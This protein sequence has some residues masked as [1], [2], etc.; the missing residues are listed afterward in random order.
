MDRYTK[1]V[2]TVIALALVGIALKPIA[3]PAYADAPATVECILPE[4]VDV[5]IAEVYGLGHGTLN[6]EVTNRVRIRE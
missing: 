1:S 4:V 2:L 6:T 5:N 3:Q